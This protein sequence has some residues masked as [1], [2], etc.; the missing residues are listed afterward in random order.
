[1]SQRTGSEIPGIEK[2]A[3][4][5]SH[6][7]ILRGNEC[8]LK[9]KEAIKPRQIYE[10]VQVKQFYA[11]KYSDSTSLKIQPQHWGGE[12]QLLT[13]VVALGYFN[14]NNIVR[15][16]NFLSVFCLY[17]RKDNNQDALDTHTHIMNIYQNLFDE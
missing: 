6:V 12:H 1:M 17:L 13:E 2:L 8:G 16:V 15:E 3:F 9:I 5:F 10:E 7:H 11:E 4:H 14:N